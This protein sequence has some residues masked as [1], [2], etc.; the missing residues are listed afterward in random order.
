[1]SKKLKIFPNYKWTRAPLFRDKY[2]KAS[3]PVISTPMK[4][5]LFIFVMICLSYAIFHAR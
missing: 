2:D 3:Y 5:V 1:M 4:I